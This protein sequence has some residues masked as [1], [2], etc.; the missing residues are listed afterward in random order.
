MIG[1]DLMMKLVL[2]L[3]CISAVSGGILFQDDFN[4]GNADGWHEI[5]MINYDVIEGMYRMY[6]GY[7]ENHG[8][9]FNGD[10]SGFMSTPDYSAVCRI[11][12]ETGVFFGM[13]CRFIEDSDYKIMLVLSYQHQALRLYRWGS[14]GL[15]ILDQTAFSVQMNHQY[16]IRYEV[17]GDIFR[18]K[19]WTGEPWE[20]PDLWM[21][22]C[23]DTLSSAGSVA[24]FC[25]G[26]TDVSLSCL[27]DDV[28]I[29]DTVSSL[30][31]HTW[32]DI[33]SACSVIM[34]NE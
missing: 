2:T 31:P 34:N 3:L 22:S 7:A 27:F 25:A 9:S 19:A 21:V 24:L 12:P 4:D 13:M 1:D 33:K 17:T 32:S 30:T 15:N 18:G 20:E 29:S 8:I 28:I 11:V 23:T 14:T 10:D 5:S 16:R 6:G 26:L